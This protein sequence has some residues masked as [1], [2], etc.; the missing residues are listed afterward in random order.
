MPTAENLKPTSGSIMRDQLIDVAREGWKNRLIDLSRRNNLLF[1]KPLV[2]GT[3]ELPV[4]SR[5]MEFVTDGETLP[6]SDLLKSDEIKLSSVRFD[7][8]QG[9]GEP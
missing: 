7:L 1:Y 9:I 8:P 5:M 4:S 2:S 6:I 3:L